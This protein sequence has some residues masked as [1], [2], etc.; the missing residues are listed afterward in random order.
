[1]KRT[2]ITIGVAMASL[3]LA[4]CATS[5]G[6]LARTEPAYVANST[7]DPKSFVTCWVGDHPEIYDVFSL[8]NGFRIIGKSQL[9]PSL[10]LNVEATPTGS[11]VTVHHQM[12]R[13]PTKRVDLCAG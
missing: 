2:A 5:S 10:L 13:T 8:D 12:V 11:R 7:L 1:M 6:K 9:Y 3:V 4:A